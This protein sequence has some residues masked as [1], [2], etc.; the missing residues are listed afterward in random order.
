MDGSASSGSTDLL[1]VGNTGNNSITVYRHDASGNTA[2]LRVIAGSKTGIDQPGQLS[3]DASGNLYVVN[4][5]AYAS[6][7]GILVF[8]R[9][10]HGDVAP[11]RKL[12]GTATGLHYVLA[13]T[14]DKN[15]GDIFAVDENV[16]AEGG[17]SL[18]RFSPDASGNEAPLAR[19]EGNLNPAVEIA[20]DSTG[21]YIVEAHAAQC[22]NSSN[23]GITT[24]S[25]HF[26]SGAEPS[27]PYEIDAF[28]PPNGLADDPTTKTYLV[29]GNSGNGGSGLYRFAET[30]TGSF[31]YMSNP[32]HIV[33]PVVSVITSET[34]GTQLAVAPGPTPNTYVTHGKQ[35]ACPTDAIYV[36]THAASGDAK[37]L[38]ILTGSATKLDKP[39]GIYEGS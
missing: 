22:C 31:P 29:T 32:E 9:G 12:A 1:Y 16:D 2:P 20:S 24:L 30:S 3:E 7:S 25:K 34:C 5:A 13:V 8:A 15:T 17:S 27:E 4:G 11:L 28:I 14:V 38:R 26:S 37:P 35:S 18:V 10:A 39:Y 33:P 21:K 23:N 36:Y 19:S 6:S